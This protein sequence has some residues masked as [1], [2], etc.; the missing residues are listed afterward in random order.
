LGGGVGVGAGQQVE[1]F[2]DVKPGIL[3]LIQEEQRVSENRS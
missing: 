2:S 3:E 1:D